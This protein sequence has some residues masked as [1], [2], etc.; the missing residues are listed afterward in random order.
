MTDMTDPTQPPSAWPQLPEEGMID[1]ILDIIAHEAH[2]DRAAL[3]PDATM[4]TLNIAS[5]DMVSI[6]F[7]VEDKFNIYIPMGDELAQ[8]VYLRD[9]I[10][11]LADQMQPGAIPAP[12]AD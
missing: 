5:I 10:K 9:L 8:T 4:E 7:E 11:V 3:V 1:R 12:K 2:I 6:L